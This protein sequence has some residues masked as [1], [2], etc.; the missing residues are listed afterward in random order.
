MKKR[1]MEDF[2][3]DSTKFRSRSPR[4]PRIG[5]ARL[6]KS[7]E[8]GAA[9]NDCPP[10]RAWTT[11]PACRADP[12]ACHPL[13][14]V[15]TFEHHDYPSDIIYF[16]TR[17]K[18]HSTTPL[19]RS[20]PLIFPRKSLQRVVLRCALNSSLWIDAQRF[21]KGHS[22]HGSPMH[23]HW[24]AMQASPHNYQLCETID[25]FSL[26]ALP[27]ARS[28]YPPASVLPENRR[29]SRLSRSPSA[30]RSTTMWKKV[31]K[32]KVRSWV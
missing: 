5:R 3:R 15:G 11:P 14:S 22:L 20:V 19:L 24:R 6:P 26:R 21:P 9:E 29:P 8:M 25:C 2:A 1:V 30:S 7:R 18:Y 27:F 16:G 12:R 28:L 4:E 10:G 13:W 23:A 32:K 17:T 31:V